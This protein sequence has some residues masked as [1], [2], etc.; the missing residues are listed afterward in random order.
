LFLIWSS[1]DSLAISTIFLFDIIAVFLF[2]ALGHL[3][4]MSE[5]A[6]GLWAGTVINDISSVVAAAFSFSD[7]VG[8]FATVVKLTRT[9]MIIP[10]TFALA[11]AHA[12]GA[13]GKGGSIDIAKIV[14]WFILGFLGA[15][16]ARSLGI[17]PD[18]G[19][20]ECQPMVILIVHASATYYVRCGT[21]LT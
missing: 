9:L 1:T 7:A 2:P 20:L 11:F 19:A 10:I 12:R 21:S 18:A 5:N 8:R 15:S 16:L 17:L 6:F 13:N 14:P 3:M 4:K